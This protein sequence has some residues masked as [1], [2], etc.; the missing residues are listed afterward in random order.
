[1][2]GLSRHNAGSGLDGNS[3]DPC[4]EFSSF[5]FELISKKFFVGICTIGL[6]IS[7]L[8]HLPDYSGY[9]DF[10]TS[11]TFTNSTSNFVYASHAYRYLLS[12]EYSDRYWLL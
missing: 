8:C 11:Y 12:T 9:G 7:R 3:N 10:G 5:Y 1:M 4:S 2:I 6:F